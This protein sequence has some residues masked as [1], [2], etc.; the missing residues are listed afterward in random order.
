MTI[1]VIPTLVSAFYCLMV[2]VCV[3]GRMSRDTKGMIRWP[4]VVMGAVAAW[5]ILRT[6]EGSWQANWASIAHSIIVI[7]GALVL[8]AMPK[9]NTH[10]GL[11]SRT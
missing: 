9:I 7:A 2:C 8:A 10:S 11:E 5:A 3:A 6:F 4:I 1:L